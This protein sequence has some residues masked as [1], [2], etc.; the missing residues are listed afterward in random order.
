M[1]FEANRTDCSGTHAINNHATGVKAMTSKL[2]MLVAASVIPAVM[3]GASAAHAAGSLAG[4]DIINNVSVAYNVGGVAQTAATASNTFDVDRKV[5]FNVD[6][7]ATTGT[8]VIAPAQLDAVTIFQVSNTSNDTLDFLLNASQLA[9]GATTPRG[10]D[11]IDFTAA[12]TFELCID[13]DNSNSCNGTET[14]VLAST[15]P[16]INDLAP[17]TNITVLARGDFA[18]TVTNGQIAGIRLTATARNSDGTAITASTDANANTA[19]IETV[20]ADAVDAFDNTSA[21]DGIAS[22]VDDYTVNAAA[23]TVTK[24]S[25]VVRDNLN[26]PNTNV[27]TTNPK[28]VPGA[29][30]EYCITVTN[31]ATAP[32]AAT[33]VVVTDNLG[34][35]TDVTYDSSFQAVLDGTVVSGNTCTPGTTNATYSGGANGIV[36]GTL[37]NIAPG[38][39]RTLVFRVTID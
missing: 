37:T 5:I 27:D 15:N 18:S 8:T 4:T 28:A 32:V 23:L 3:M 17:D 36:S 10:T 34:T 25:R 14:W 20:F 1:T 11:A 16:S 21:R 31:A 29:T 19:G 6:E 39:T 38:Q 9:V 24:L 35:E 30:V 2:K 12:S 33:N 22:A 26:G 13:A 7:K